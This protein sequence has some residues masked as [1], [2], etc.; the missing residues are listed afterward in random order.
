MTRHR[1]TLRSKH[2]AYARLAAGSALAG[3]GFYRSYKT[4]RAAMPLPLP[5]ATAV[6]VAHSIAGTSLGL[7]LAVHG[8]RGLRA[9]RASR[10][11]LRSARF[12]RSPSHQFYGNQYVRGTYVRASQASPVA[13]TRKSAKARSTR[14]GGRRS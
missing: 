12:G 13:R 3:A 14:R 5:H 10:S 8:L 4:L 2:R 9:L 6:R 7:R 1:R 11:G